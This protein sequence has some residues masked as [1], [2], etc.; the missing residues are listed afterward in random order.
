M[1]CDCI[2]QTNARMKEKGMNSRLAVTILLSGP[3]AG[4]GRLTIPTAWEDRPKSGNGF[5]RREP[6]AM[7]LTHCPFCFIP[8]EDSH[9]EIAPIRR[10]VR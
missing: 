5:T 1:A 4:Q 10:P 8:Y 6:P 2:E 9:K 7:L 3:S